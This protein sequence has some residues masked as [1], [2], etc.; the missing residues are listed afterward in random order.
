MKRRVKDVEKMQEENKSIFEEQQ[1]VNEILEDF[2]NRQIAR[3]QLE[4]NWQLNINFFIGNQYCGI[5]TNGDIVDGYKQYFW[6]ERE[7]FN[8]IAPLVELRLSKL[9]NVRPSLTVLPFSDEMEDIASAKVSKKILKS[10]CHE[11]GF[12]KLLQEATRW[13]EICG[14]AFYK[15]G[16]NDKKG[17]FIAKNETGNKIYEGDVEVSVVS[18]FEIYPDSNTYSSIEECESIIYARSFSSK[19]VKNKWGVEVEGKTINVFSLDNITS[20]GGLGYNATSS[21]LAK[22]TKLDQVI[23]L[24]KYESPSIEYPNGRLII[25]AGD[26][27]VYMGELPYINKENGERGFPFV[28]QCAI[29]IPNSFF[30]IS[31]IDRCIPIQRAYN[32]IKNRKH[33]FLNRLTMGILAV[34]DGSVDTEDLEEEGLSPGKVLIYRQGSN[35]PKLLSTGSVPLDFQYEENQL[36]S[37]FLNVSGVNDLLNAKTISTNISGV[38]LQLLIEQDEVRLLSS[39]EEIRN[40]AKET[41]KQMLRL[42]KQFAFLPHTSRIVGEDGGIEMFYWQNSDI[43]ADDIVFETENEINETVAQKRSMILDI[44]KTGLLHDEDGKLS[45]SVRT[46]LLEQLGMGLSVLD[47]EQDLKSLQTKQATKE[48][49]RLIDEDIIELPKEIDEHDIHISSHIG[50]MLSKEFDKA[51][52]KN[53]KLEKKLLEHIKDHKRYLNLTKKA[54]EMQN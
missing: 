2:K 38:A 43:Q 5:N 35:A 20:V 29:P 54:E 32:A 24:E 11:I 17:R 27:L 18:P 41:A 15:I 10:V 28:R 3:R 9:A 51:S 4:T 30:G 19:E 42:F 23:V 49:L 8:H 13:S 14:T 48:N 36:L 46:K 22:T 25:I 33:E 40:A 31:T 1:L 37:E 26:K 39:A 12:S 44:L 50:F 7:V 45:N 34:E 6:E 53:P 16:W 52:K 47:N 21:S